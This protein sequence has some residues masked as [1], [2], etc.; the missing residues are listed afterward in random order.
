MNLSY[1][2]Q[3]FNIST[4]NIAL[5]ISSIILQIIKSLTEELLN[6]KT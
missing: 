4:T 3:V 1:L 6:L 5:G 2:V